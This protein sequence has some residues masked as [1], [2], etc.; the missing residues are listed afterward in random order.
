VLVSCCLTGSRISR[1]PKERLN[2]IGQTGHCNPPQKL[3]HRFFFGFRNI[4]G[5]KMLRLSVPKRLEKSSTWKGWKCLEP[6]AKRKKS[7]DESAH[8]KAAVRHTPKPLA[9][10]GF[11]DIVGNHE[12]IV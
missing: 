8:S 6:T 4:N 12:H 3:R 11:S 9:I 10:R 5:S 2:Y 7:G 1:P